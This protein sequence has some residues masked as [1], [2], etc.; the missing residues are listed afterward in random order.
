MC[1]DAYDEWTMPHCIAWLHRYVCKMIRR[2]LPDNSNFFF[3][4]VWLRI[5][6]AH[7][8]M[9]LAVS[10]WYQPKIFLRQVFLRRTC[11][12]QH[13]TELSHTLRV[14][15]RVSSIYFKYLQ[16]FKN[17]LIYLL[18]YFIELFDRK[19]NLCAIFLS[20]FI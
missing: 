3:F 17:V 10:S 8:K 11:R 1:W 15:P 18:K 20:F 2:T 14:T 13:H 7:F 16:L 5:E 19:F 4:L 9:A 12:W 6:N